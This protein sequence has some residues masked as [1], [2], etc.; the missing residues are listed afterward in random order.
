MVQERDSLEG[1]NTIVD[2]MGEYQK[3]DP[4]QVQVVLDAV[5][6]F[7]AFSRDSAYDILHQ[8]S[9][10]LCNWFV[11]L[12]G[13]HF[14]VNFDFKLSVDFKTG[15]IQGLP[16]SCIIYN[17][18]KWKAEKSTFEE[19]N[20]LTNGEFGITAKVDYHDDGI[21]MFDYKFLKN[22]LQIIIK[23]YLKSRVEISRSKSEVVANTK[24]E[25]LK[26]AIL[27]ITQ[28]ISNEKNNI[29]TNFEGN[30]YFCGVPHGTKEFI[31]SK[32][33]EYCDKLQ[34]RVN[35]IPFLKSEFMKYIICKKFYIYGKIMYIMRTVIILKYYS[36]WRDKLQKIHN[37]VENQEITSTLI[38]E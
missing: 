33:N 13:T 18:I 32:M 14:R 21:T 19:L 26:T 9:P 17:A 31:C 28:D 2:S 36:E 7:N 38:T 1:V 22:Y 10:I 27:A 29:K 20:Q 8:N 35:Y 3:I 37:F 25:S 16:S 11:F 6:A 12:Y 4:N 30:I 5:N 23:N 15:A 24:D 34:T